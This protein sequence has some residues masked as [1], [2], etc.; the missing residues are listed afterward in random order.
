M[1]GSKLRRREIVV[2]LSTEG[3][4]QVMEVAVGECIDRGVKESE[5]FRCPEDCDCLKL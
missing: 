5:S 3:E 1:Y 4:W 2:F